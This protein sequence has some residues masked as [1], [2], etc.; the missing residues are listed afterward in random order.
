MLKNHPGHNNNGHVNQGAEL[1]EIKSDQ[2]DNANNN[3]EEKTE[4]Q[5]SHM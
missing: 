4:Y 1:S 2:P 5:T 3:N